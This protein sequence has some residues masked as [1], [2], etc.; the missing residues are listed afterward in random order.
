MVSSQGH[1]RLGRSIQDRKC[2]SLV[3]LQPE[4]HGPEAEA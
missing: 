4:G 3:D 1:A 2:G